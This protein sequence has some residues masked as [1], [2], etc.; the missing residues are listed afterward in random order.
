[1]IPFP[2]KKYQIIYAD[3]CWSYKDKRDKHKRLCGGAT[4]H[5]PTMSMQ[6]IYNLPVKDIADDNCWLFLWITFPNLIECT[7]TIKQWGFKYKTLGF[8][9]IKTNKKNGKP[10]F[11]IGYY[12]KSNAEV[13]LIGVKGKVKPVSNSVSSVLIEPRQ[14]H[15]KKPDIV[16]N[17]IVQLCG[18][19]PRIELF[20]RQK[21][22]GWDAWG[23]EV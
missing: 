17:K 3:P 8:S 2:N 14:E 20:A 15:S 6:D 22:E 7:E 4:S 12:T 13:C 18:D 5:Y 21:T 9:W 23:N 10:F 1:M 16:R 19:I 11:G